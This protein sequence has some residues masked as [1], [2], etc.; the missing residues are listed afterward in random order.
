MDKW[1]QLQDDLRKEASSIL[2]SSG[3]VVEVKADSKSNV[4]LSLIWK[5]GAR[6]MRVTYIPGNNSVRWDTTGQHGFEPIAEFTPI[7]AI[8]L[9]QRLFRR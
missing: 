6:H 5:G 9:M 1:Q 8:D 2:K 7:L 4:D 3:E